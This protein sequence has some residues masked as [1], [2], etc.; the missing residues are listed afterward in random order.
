MA[1]SVLVALAG[2]FL[3]RQLYLKSLSIPESLAKKWSG[4]YNLLYNK[5]YVDQIYDSLFVNRA[6]DLG[7]ALGAFDRGIVNGIFIDGSGWLTRVLSRISAWWDSWIVDGT[8]NL[9]ARIVWVF[10]VPV[11]ML[12]SGRVANYALLMVIGVL[13]FLGI[14]LSASGVTPMSTLQQLWR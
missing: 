6:K 3:A 13:I 7:N 9:V 5:Y 8:V 14:Y 11:R 1:V 2:I 12:Q 4:V 10:S